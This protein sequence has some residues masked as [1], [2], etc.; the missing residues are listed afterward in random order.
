[1]TTTDDQH[2]VDPA[3]GAPA[4][5]TGPA[6]AARTRVVRQI[7]KVRDLAPL[8]QFKKPTLPGRRQ[9][10]DSALT[11]WDLRAIAARRT[12]RAAFDYTEGAAEAEISLARARQAFEDIEF[13]PAILRDVSHVDTSRHVLG[14]PTALPF[15]IAPTGFTRMM[16]TEGE[17]AGARAAGRAGIPFSLS[18]MGTTAIED[19]KAANPHGRN[20]FQLYMWKDRDKSMALVDRAARAGFDTLL[21]TV[22]VPVAGARLRDKRN[23]FSIPPQLGV[24]TIVNA[25]PRPWWWF[26]FLT[27]EPLAF[28]SLD[29]WSGTVGELLDHMFDPTVTYEDLA[30]IRDQWPGKVVVKGVQSLDDAKRLT[31]MGVDGITL[32]NHGGRQLDRAPVPFH[33]LPSVVK[34]V[35]AD[36]EVHLDTGIMSGADIIAAIALG[37][38]F[39][40]VGRA[41]LYGLMAGGEAGVDRMIQILSDQIERTMRLLGVATLDELRPGHV[42]QLQRLTPIPR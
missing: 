26:D 35:G 7:P 40:M 14:A 11:I 19:V 22:D 37:A 32:S 6:S 42:T 20:W 18:T 2:R 16:Q 3:T 28:A 27:T 31:A 29:R 24:K 13:T 34:E 30:W 33:L 25:I 17:R 12:P 15:G 8:L 5:S 4:A 1:M 10:L 36:T 38:K 41:Y 39:T 9:R 21:V 23:G